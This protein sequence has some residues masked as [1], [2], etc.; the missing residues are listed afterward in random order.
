M[1]R[2]NLEGRIE[3]VVQGGAGVEA[4][5]RKPTAEGVEGVGPAFEGGEQVGQG[6]DIE[7]R[8]RALDELAVAGGNDEIIPRPQALVIAGGN[9][10]C[11]EG[12]A[13]PWRLTFEVTRDQRLH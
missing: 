13:S 9:A 3:A 2:T 6:A 7:P 8:G 1:L 4:V 12:L 10:A 11:G 5:V